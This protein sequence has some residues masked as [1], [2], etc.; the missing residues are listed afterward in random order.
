MHTLFGILAAIRQQQGFFVARY[1]QDSRDVKAEKKRL[2]DARWRMLRLGLDLVRCIGLRSRAMVY[3]GISPALVREELG[4]CGDAI[5]VYLRL[6]FRPG[7]S[8]WQRALQ[9]RRL[10]VFSYG[11][12]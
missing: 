2:F 6:L 7:A 8:R 10:L 9:L 11:H 3:V 12:C 4:I 5:S 1:S